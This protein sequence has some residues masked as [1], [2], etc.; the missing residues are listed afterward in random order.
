MRKANTPNGAG[1]PIG[2]RL[3]RLAYRRRGKDACWPSKAAPENG[4]V[5]LSVGGVV[6]SAARLVWTITHGLPPRGRVFHRC[7]RA[8]CLRPEHLTLTP[9][10]HRPSRRRRRDAVLTP[11]GVRRIRRALRTDRQLKRGIRPDL[12]LAAST[13]LPVAP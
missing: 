4:A 13:T 2:A 8:D 10:P 12:L 11:A 1:E 3:T 6:S 9:Q 5:R 7:R